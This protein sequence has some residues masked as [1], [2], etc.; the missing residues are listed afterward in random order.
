[1]CCFIYLFSLKGYVLS[2]E[3]L[4]R[5][6]NLA[7]KGNITNGTCNFNSNSGNEDV[8][9]G[10][11]L[12]SVNVKVGDS[13]DKQKRHRFHSDTVETYIFSDR[14]TPKM[15]PVLYHP[16]KKVNTR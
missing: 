4:R 5:F 1:M 10:S 8:E 3:A 9:L 2:T 14:W 15:A 12:E 16:I 11:C 6:V 13:R 7:L